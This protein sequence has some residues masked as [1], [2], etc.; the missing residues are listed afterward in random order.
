MSKL[1]IPAPDDGQGDL[2]GLSDELSV[3]V[4]LS[5]LLIVGG[6]YFWILPQVQQAPDPLAYIED[7]QEREAVRDRQRFEDLLRK[8]QWSPQR[9]EGAEGAR[10][11]AVAPREMREAL[12]E[13]QR[14]AL[15]GGELPSDQA[16]AL[17][18]SVKERAKEAPW[19]CLVR[20][21]LE[22]ELADGEELTEAVAAFWEEAEALDA[23][24]EVLEETIEAFRES[25]DR[26][27]GERFYR[28]LRRCAMRGDYRSGPACRRLVRQLAPA[29]GAELLEM[30]VLHLSQEEAPTR[31]E[32]LEVVQ[33]LG[34]LAL[35]GQPASWV[36]LETEKL[37]DYDADLRLGAIYYLCRMANSPDEVVERG[38]RLQL[39]RVA[40]FGGRPTNPH[41][42]YRWRRTC[43]A[44]FGDAEDPYHATPVLG[45][46]VATEDGEEPEIDYGMG[47]L[48]AAGICKEEEG[49]P[50]WY[51][52][53]E[54]WT[55]KRGESAKRVLATHFAE[56]GYVEWQELE[57]LAEVYGEETVE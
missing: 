47:A 3:A 51:C 6:W 13:A 10:I 27:D 56:S 16:Q 49:Y 33:A 14:E 44:A 2:G 28:W 45:V 40:E 50:L 37:P 8:G 5:V 29:Q 41:M 52:G 15:I 24:G 26:P 11:F 34:T 30:I 4:L 9:S 46:L 19:T 35:R 25:R 17:L 23:H 22:G 57:E 36:V 12:C 21:Y 38:A 39:G 31:M 48:V 43:R 20:Q 32:L 42:T 55:G 18:E 53:A 7:I 54:R 1:I